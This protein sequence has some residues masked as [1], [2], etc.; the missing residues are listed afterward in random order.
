MAQVMEEQ[1][2]KNIKYII[3]IKGQP[4][5]IWDYKEEKNLK[6][7]Q[8][9]IPAISISN[10]K[11]SI[12]NKDAVVF[13]SRVDK[14][15]DIKIDLEDDILDEI[16]FTSREKKSGH[17]E[18]SESIIVQKLREMVIDFEYLLKQKLK[19][20]IPVGR[21]ARKKYFMEMDIFEKKG[22]RSYVESIELKV[23]ALTTFEHNYSMDQFDGYENDELRKGWF[24]K[25]INEA[26]D[27][28]FNSALEVVNSVEQIVKEEVYGQPKRKIITKIA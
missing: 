17:G 18:E 19:P 20:D 2:K 28:N 10:P 24:K 5:F 15:D 25:K 6:L 8:K 27:G 12:L 11:D 22:Y 3:T 13:P 14:N 16:K 9:L 4:R 23:D 1:P 7:D 26:K 21:R